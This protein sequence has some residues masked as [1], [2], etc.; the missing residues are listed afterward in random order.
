MNKLS[1]QN[2]DQKDPQTYAVIGAAM[3]VYNTLRGG[4]LEAVYQEA[5]EIEFHLRE[6][7]YSRETQI[8]IQYKGYPLPTCYRADFVCF[9]GIIVE[10]KAIERI[11]NIER[12]Q[13]IHYLKATGYKRGLLINLGPKE[14]VFERLVNNF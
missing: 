1:D 8:P 13:I 11:S 10:L 5:L 4:F 12:A 14:L 2:T 9:D 7:P 3:E 6:V